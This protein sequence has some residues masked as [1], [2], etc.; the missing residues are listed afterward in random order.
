MEVDAS[1]PFLERLLSGE[2]R[3][4]IFEN[5]MIWERAIYIDMHIAER[6]N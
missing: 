2:E 5:E 4:S 1:N 6:Q 3:E